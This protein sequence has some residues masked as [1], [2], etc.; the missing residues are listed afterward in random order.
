MRLVRFLAAFTMVFVLAL[1]VTAQTGGQAGGAA[2]AAGGQRG[3]APVPMVMTIAAFPDGTDI[4]VKY[5]AA[6][7]QTSPAIT[8]TNAPAGTVTFLLHMHDLE[9]SRNHT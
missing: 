4:P 9:G 1:A 6:G 2:P 5:T 8:W 3:P 7:D